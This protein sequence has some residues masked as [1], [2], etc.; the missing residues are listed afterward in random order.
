MLTEALEKMPHAGPMRLI[1]EI[2]S[3]SAEEI[4]CIARDHS[5]DS[6][7]LRL[8]K[9]LHCCTLVELGAQAAAAHTSLYGAC[10]AHMGLVLAFRNVEV[11]RDRIEGDGPLTIWAEQRQ[12]LEDAAQYRFEVMDRDGAV[13]AGD[14]LLSLQRGAL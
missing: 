4:R 1:E 3:A 12:S 6:Y 7:P 13:V 8:D 11:F 10:G 14:I 2:V 5:A 9:V